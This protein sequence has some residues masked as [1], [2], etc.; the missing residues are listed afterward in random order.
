M[1]RQKPSPSGKA[2]ELTVRHVA[3]VPV[4]GLPVQLRLMRPDGLRVE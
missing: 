2:L 4:D 3:L 1:A